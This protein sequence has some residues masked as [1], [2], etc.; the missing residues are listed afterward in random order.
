MEKELNGQL[1]VVRTALTSDFSA[2]ACIDKENRHIYWKCAYGNQND[3]YQLLVEK[4]GQGL[5]GLVVRQ[6][7]YVKIDDSNHNL[8]EKQLKYPLMI[9]EHLKAAIAVPIKVDQ[10]ICGVLLVGD[11]SERVYTKQ[12]IE[13]VIKATEQIAV[14]QKKHFR[15]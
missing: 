4:A 10:K 6:G 8:K 5:A 15:N 14:L 12:D 7:S 13:K 9:A 2:L 1:Q 3:R 11:R